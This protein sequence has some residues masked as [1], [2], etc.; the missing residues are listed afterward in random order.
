LLMD[1]DIQKRSTMGSF[2]TRGKVPQPLDDIL[3]SSSHPNVGIYIVHIC[4]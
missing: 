3:K 2:I 4:I 1:W